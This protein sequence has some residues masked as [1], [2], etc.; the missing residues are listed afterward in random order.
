[1]KLR[2]T[3][4]PRIL[5]SLGAMA[6]VLA[7]GGSAAAGVNDREARQRSRIRAGVE[8]GSLTRG[9]AHRL[10]HEQ[11]RIERTERRFRR[12]DGKLGP[13]ERIRLDRKLDRSA[14]HLYRARHNDRERQQ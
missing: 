12:N 2:A 11:A 8:D 9:E 13:R 3:R 6:L 5:V 7:I 14:V 1:M 10:V 4:F